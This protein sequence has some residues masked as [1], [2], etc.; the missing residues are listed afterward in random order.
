L[1][2]SADTRTIRPSPEDILVGGVPVEKLQQA[3]LRVVGAV[4]L[5]QIPAVHLHSLGE[6]HCRHHRGVPDGLQ[7]HV[8]AV[9]R[10]LQFDHDEVRVAVHAEEVDAALAFVPLAELLGQ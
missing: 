7:L 6:C 1:E 5:R 10:P 2:N 3:G 4:V 8:A 9:L